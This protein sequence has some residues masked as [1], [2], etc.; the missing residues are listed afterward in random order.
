MTSRLATVDDIKKEVESYKG[1]RVTLEAHRSKKKLFQKE[2]VIEAVYPCIFTVRIQEEKRAP[3]RLSFSYT[4]IL[5]HN[6]KIGLINE[7]NRSFAY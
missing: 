2:G 3:Q 4:D 6:V 1:C 7:D 5:T